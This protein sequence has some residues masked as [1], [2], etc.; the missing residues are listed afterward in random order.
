MAKLEDAHGLGPCGVTLGGS[1]PLIRTQYME[2]VIEKQEDG[3]II[4]NITIP[5]KTVKET[6]DE[7]IVSIA[8]SANI[9]GFRKGKAPKKIVEGKI[10]KDRVKEDVLKKLLPKYYA[11]AVKKHNIRPI[12]NPRIHVGTL[13]EDKDWKFTAST[14]EAPEVDLNGYKENIKKITARSKIAIPGKEDK[15][16]SFDE[17]MIELQKSVKVKV[18][19]II[20]EQEVE[21]LLA[22]TLDEIKRLG[23]TL[24]QYLTSTRKTVEDLKAEYEKKA[25]NDIT[26]EFTLQKIAEEEKIIATD[27][28]IEDTIKNVKDENERRGLETNKYLLAS[29][30]RQQK[31]LDFLKKL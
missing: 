31:T 28:E 29:V 19:K 12:I 8:K 11:D 27:N 25:V 20:V 24:D 23:L 15:E 22:Q 2:S 4:L 6:T 21:R 10:D 5:Q 16:A 17:I 14:C 7:I 18:S 30:I 26:L 9:A 1:S 13:E 3:T